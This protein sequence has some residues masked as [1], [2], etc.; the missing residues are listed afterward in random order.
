MTSLVFQLGA[1]GV[2]ARYAPLARSSRLR[3]RRRLL[4]LRRKIPSWIN[5]ILLVL[6]ADAMLA[7]VAWGAVAKIL[8]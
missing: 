3:L 5:L 2:A 4:R 8:R 7:I 1:A 6:I